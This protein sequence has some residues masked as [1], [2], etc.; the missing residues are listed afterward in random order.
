M[1][2]DLP[3][4]FH[5]YNTRMEDGTPV[6]G[7][8]LDGLGYDASSDAIYLENEGIY[9]Y[10]NV[11]KGNDN[12]DAAA[13]AEQEVA[14]IADIDDDA[15]YLIE[16]NGAYV[17]ILKGSSLNTDDYKGKTIRKANDRGGFGDAVLIPST[18]TAVEQ[19]DINAK[20]SK[21]LRNGI[22]L[23]EKNGKLYN[24]QGIVVR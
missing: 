17:D 11:V 16:D 10:E 9:T 7:H 21:I 5:E 3:V 15:A 14:D 23:I 22:L 8:S 4:R 12:W 6:T 19:T 20:A 2:A 18:A 24:A 13:I 1:S